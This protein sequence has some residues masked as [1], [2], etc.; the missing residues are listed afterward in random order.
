MKPKIGKTELAREYGICLKTLTRWILPFEDDLKKTGYY[1]NKK[2][3][4]KKQISIIYE[5]L[6]EP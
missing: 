6:G 4:T 5:K 2:S 3:F 1:R